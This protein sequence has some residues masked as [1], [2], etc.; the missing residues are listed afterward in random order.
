MEIIYRD[1][2]I[3]VLN[4]PPGISAHGG[5]RVSGETVADFLKEK[6][7]EIHTVGDDPARPGIVHR[8]D[9]D[10][11]GVMVAARNQKSFEILK[12]LFQKRLVEKVYWAIVCGA[13]KEKRGTITLPIGR[14]AKN[15]TKRGADLGS[16]AS[17]KLRL[18]GAR[19]AI[20]A[21]RVLKSGANYSL[22]ELKPKTGRMH[23]LRVH[24]KAIGHPVACDLK[25]GGN[26][27]C[28]PEGVGRQLLHAQSISFSIAEGKRL[29]FEADP[30]PDFS[31]AETRLF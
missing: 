28:C 14:L 30:P 19:E 18:R 13:P 29:F 15:P 11:S 5:E 2:N 26:Q 6:F 27:V 1:E 16:V 4:K 21:Y 20:T 10:T 31:L 22:L 3:I 7:P 9:K 8:L 12:S 25:Y 24:L 17:K 23:Q